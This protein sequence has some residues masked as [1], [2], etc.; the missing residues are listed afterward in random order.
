MPERY[1]IRTFSYAFEAVKEQ[2]VL[3]KPTP[4]LNPTPNPSPEIT[5]IY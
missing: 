1:A 5:N 4:M 3:D 2:M